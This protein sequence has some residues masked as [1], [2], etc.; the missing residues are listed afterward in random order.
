MEN[1]QSA[2]TITAI[3]AETESLC[4]TALPPDITET[5]IRFQDVVL[6]TLR[7][8]DRILFGHP[9][10]APLLGSDEVVL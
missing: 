7:E 8:A 9:W 4:P 3:L 2:S 5:G 1:L 6:L 10:A